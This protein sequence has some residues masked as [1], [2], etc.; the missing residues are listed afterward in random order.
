MVGF[1]N[2]SIFWHIIIVVIIM[3][4]GGFRRR[5]AYFGMLY[6]MY[7]IIVVIIMNCGGF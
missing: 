3:N 4:C 2:D 1:E 7:V 6:S 5:V